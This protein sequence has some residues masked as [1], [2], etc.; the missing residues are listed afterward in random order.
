MS[1]S[2]TLTKIYQDCHSSLL[3][4]SR[5]SL[6]PKNGTGVMTVKLHVIAFDSVFFR[7]GGTT[8]QSHDF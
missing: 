5:K 7:G 2:Q 6:F 1:R 8:K 3:L 4:I